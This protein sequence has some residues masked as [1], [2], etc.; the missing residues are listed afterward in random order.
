M[1]GHLNASCD[2]NTRYLVCDIPRDTVEVK[3]K[4]KTRWGKHTLTED[5]E[6]RMGKLCPCGKSQC[7]IKVSA[8]GKVESQ[9]QKKKHDSGSS[10]DSET[11][12]QVGEG[13]SYTPKFFADNA[14]ASS[15]KENDPQNDAKLVMT[16]KT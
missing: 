16:F 3:L 13:F 5:K 14:T 15:D 11:W 7:K 6:R 1:G 2:F 12:I 9:S 4:I 8:S 10:S